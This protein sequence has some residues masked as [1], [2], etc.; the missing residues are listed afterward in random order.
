MALYRKSDWGSPLPK[1]G[2]GAIKGAAGNVAV[3]QGIKQANFSLMTDE[4]E[5]PLLLMN[6]VLGVGQEACPGSSI[7]L[8]LSPPV[9][10]VRTL[11]Y[12]G[13]THI[14]R[15][16]TVAAVGV[17]H[18]SSQKVRI[19]SAAAV[20]RSAAAVSYG[21]SLSWAFTAAAHRRST[22]AALIIPATIVQLHPI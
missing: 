4:D 9:V 5:Y 10:R 16:G 14:S 17:R 8:A 15:R 7:L 19:D 18:P 20:S 3:C 21:G 2:R 12:V 22:R 11:G 13:E 1:K 6:T